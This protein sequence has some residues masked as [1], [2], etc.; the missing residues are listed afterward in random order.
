MLAC[1]E[2]AASRASITGQ[3]RSRDSMKYADDENEPVGWKQRFPHVAE[4]ET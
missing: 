3:A 1:L 2:A 4:K